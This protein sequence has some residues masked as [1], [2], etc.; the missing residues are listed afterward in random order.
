[1]YLRREENRLV[2]WAAIC[3]FP[4]DLLFP[5][6]HPELQLET[7]LNKYPR[8]EPVSSQAPQVFLLTNHFVSR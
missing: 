4:L 5:S 8:H 7:E 2:R 1:M 3:M 6:Q